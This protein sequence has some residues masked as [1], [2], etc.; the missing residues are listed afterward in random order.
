MVFPTW[1]ES[2]NRVISLG[3]FWRLEEELGSVIQEGA[4]LE[5]ILLNKAQCE[6]TLETVNSKGGSCLRNAF[7]WLCMNQKNPV[8]CCPHCTLLCGPRGWLW[9]LVAGR[10]QQALQSTGKEAAPRRVASSH[11]GAGGF[12]ARP[13]SLW[14]LAF[15]SSQNLWLIRM[16]GMELCMQALRLWLPISVPANKLL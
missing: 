12:V 16:N 9:L 7:Y 3:Q 11:W 2:K 1:F 10:H 5:K 4:K 13:P 6:Q 8:I 14:L 15:L